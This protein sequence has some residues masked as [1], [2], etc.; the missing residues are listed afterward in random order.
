MSGPDGT[1]RPLI[2]ITTYGRLQ[3]GRFRLPAEYVDAVRR[4]GGA[5]VLLPPGETAIDELIEGLDGFI[6]SGGGD[7]APSLYGGEAHPAI[8]R[9]DPE[10]DAFE[11]AL[12]R[13]LV[14]RQVPALHICR[15][16]QV[17]NVALGG[18]LH[19]HLPDVV[20]EG[21][22]HREAKPEG[23][24]RHPVRVE[25]GSRLATVMGDMQPAPVSSHHQAPDRVAAPLRVVARASDGT[26]E[27]LELPDHPWLLAVQ[28]HPES[29]A[30][31][32]ATQQR[33][34]DGLVAAARRRARGRLER[35]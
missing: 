13:A 17:L 30:R 15:G 22:A 14:E 20:G 23:E 18:S 25:P 8:D 10:R 5:P 27:G 16:C 35:R 1:S 32:D 9:V 34:F 33:L 24:A 3:D 2:G 29:S 26:I 12:V 28:W 7:V 6:L 11:I 4:A 31:E 19:E 21:L